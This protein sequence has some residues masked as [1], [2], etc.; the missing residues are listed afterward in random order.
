METHSELDEFGL[1]AADVLHGQDEELKPVVL[2]QQQK[3]GECEFK[4]LKKRI[5]MSSTIFK[6]MSA[7]YFLTLSM[8][9][10]RAV[11][12]HILQEN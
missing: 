6:P 5:N 3:S 2:L 10:I 4:K 7:M 11:D 1:G 12:M 9:N 8:K